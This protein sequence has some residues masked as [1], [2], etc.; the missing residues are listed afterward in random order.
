MLT[1]VVD[2]TVR[3]TVGKVLEGHTFTSIQVII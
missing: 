2:V 3:R 1:I